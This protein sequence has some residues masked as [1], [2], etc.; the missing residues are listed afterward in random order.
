MSAFDEAAHA[1]AEH[2]DPEYVAG[3]DVKSGVDED[4]S[5]LFARSICAIR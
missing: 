3:Y 4:R 2:V 5:G 1:G